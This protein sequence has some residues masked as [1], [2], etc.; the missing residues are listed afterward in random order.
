MGEIEI[1][2]IKQGFVPVK[3]ELLKMM[4]KVNWEKV[5]WSNFAKFKANSLFG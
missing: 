1:K 2:S 3:A 5:F 4:V